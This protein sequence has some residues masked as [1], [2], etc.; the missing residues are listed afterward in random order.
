M[1]KLN[2]LIIGLLLALMGCD[3]NVSTKASTNI[4][5]KMLEHHM[6]PGASIKLQNPQPIYVAAVGTENLELQLSSTSGEGVLHIDLTTSEGLELVSSQTHYEFPMEK[7]KTYK[8]P[9]QISA[10]EQGRYYINIKA[11]ISNGTEQQHRVV[12]AIVQIGEP[13]VKMLK[14]STSKASIEQD[15]VI[16]MPA[17]ENIAP[18]Q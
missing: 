13:A 10:A 1:F 8:L 12:A 15:P 9:L 6:K 11:Q 5:S 17:K 16:E 3:A 2:I 7:N 18:V 14:N 4:S